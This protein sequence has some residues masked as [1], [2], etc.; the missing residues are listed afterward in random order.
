MKSKLTISALAL[1]LLAGTA[2]AQGA[3]K[4]ASKQPT[5]TKA[6]SSQMHT[7]VASGNIVSVDDNKLVLS[8]KVKGKAQEM[9]FDLTPS[10]HKT[11]KLQAG[12]KATVHYRV[13]NGNNVAT[14]VR[15]SS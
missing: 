10:T 7:R 11:G 6:A 15:A 4:S 1:A 13:E 8:H 5:A 14:D 2:W 9:S 3:A 12:S